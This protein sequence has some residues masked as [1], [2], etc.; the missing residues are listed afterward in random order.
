MFRLRHAWMVAAALGLAACAQPWWTDRSDLAQSAIL[1]AGG[2]PVEEAGDND[3]CVIWRLQAVDGA[4]VP[5]GSVY[6]AYPK[7]RSPEGH[8]GLVLPPGRHKI[9]A[10]SDRQP[11]HDP[12][13][14]S[15]LHDIGCINTRYECVLFDAVLEPGHIYH[16]YRTETGAIVLRDKAS[17]QPVTEGR[18]VGSKSGWFDSRQ[19]VDFVPLKP[20]PI[21]QLSSS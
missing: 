6:A 9:H 21:D 11:S 20:G 1:T 19:C 3:I 8:V 10:M 18:I 13:F 4:A 15:L 7:A 16:P 14:G 2:H 12:I 5:P 17:G